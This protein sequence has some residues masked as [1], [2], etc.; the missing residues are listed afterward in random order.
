MVKVAAP[1]VGR[2]TSHRAQHEHPDHPARAAP[3]VPGRRR[4]PSRT[5]GPLE[6]RGQGIRCRRATIN[7][8]TV[9]VGSAGS[10]NVTGQ[11]FLDAAATIETVVDRV[12]DVRVSPTRD[13]EAARTPTSS[14][15]PFA[16]HR[17]GGP[18]STEPAHVV[19]TRLRRRAPHPIR[20]RCKVGDRRVDDDF[21]P[22]RQR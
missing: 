17:A 20:P 3:G 11:E 16:L 10:G 5:A 19:G 18:V 2:S 8:C 4:E 9:L 6:Q 7:M 14:G 13:V 21:P 12:P 22:L 15:R 1:N